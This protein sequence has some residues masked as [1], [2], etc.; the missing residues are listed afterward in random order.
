VGA[1]GRHRELLICSDLLLLRDLLPTAIESIAPIYVVGEVFEEMQIHPIEESADTVLSAFNSSIGG[2]GLNVC[3]WC[4][5]LG[6]RATLFGP[7]SIGSVA[8]LT[9]ETHD[10]L[11]DRTTAVSTSAGRCVALIEPSR[12]RFYFDRGANDAT[13]VDLSQLTGGHRAVVCLSAHGSRSAYFEACLDR[14]AGQGTQLLLDLGSPA[15]LVGGG[16]LVRALRLAHVVR[17]NLDEWIA[18]LDHGGMRQATLGG[19]AKF[20]VLSLGQGGLVVYDVKRQ[21]ATGCSIRVPIR[22]TDTVGA[23]DATLGAI[24]CGMAC[25]V[26]P[27]LVASLANACGSLS[28]QQAGGCGPPTFGVPGPELSNLIE[29]TVIRRSIVGSF[30]GLVR[31]SASPGNLLSQGIDQVDGWDR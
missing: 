10:W 28:V 16:S 22:V 6:L 29:E 7:I 26:S 15:V 17:G 24:A 20:F 2:F 23:G 1:I 18:V 8:S 30:E 5:N 31:R 9:G 19:E 27:P 3:R 11:M 25:G 21:V 12:H 4:S 14:I 13:G